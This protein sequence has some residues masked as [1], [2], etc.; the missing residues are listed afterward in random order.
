MAYVWF[1]LSPQSPLLELLI[2]AVANFVLGVF[3]PVQLH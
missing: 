2:N 1:T 3:A